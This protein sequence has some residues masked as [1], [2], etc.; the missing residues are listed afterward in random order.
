MQTLYDIA[1]LAVVA[2]AEVLADGTSPNTNSGVGT[3]KTGTGQYT[4]VLPANMQQS[5]ARD[6][7]FVTPKKSLTDANAGIPLSH[8]VDDSNS[9]LK[10]IAIYG[11]SPLQTFADAEFSVIIFRTIV[12]PPANSP[13]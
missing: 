11:G 3:L 8:A 5:A 4:V 13:A 7:M 1:G 9:A 12:P 10:R 6:L 2:Y